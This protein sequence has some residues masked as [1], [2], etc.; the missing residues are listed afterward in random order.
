MNRLEGPKPA[1]RR[2]EP[3]IVLI[4]LGALAAAGV[5]SFAARPEPSPRQV[6]AVALDIS[7][8]NNRDAVCDDLVAIIKSATSVQS[9]HEL[10]ILASGGRDTANEPVKVASFALEP[11]RRLVE[12][13]QAA[14]ARRNQISVEAKQA[15]DRLPIRQESPIFQMVDTAT[16]YFANRRCGTDGLTCLILVRTDGIDETDAIMARRFRD[17]KFKAPPR[18]YNLHI[19]V[20]FCGLSARRTT[21]K[22]RLP[23]LSDVERAFREEFTEPDL[24]SFSPDCS[25]QESLRGGSAR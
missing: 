17:S 20:H 23:S 16:K 8:T 11:S 1:A 7:A 25:S 10:T 15:C 21:G 2:L 24:V 12:G 4:V 6:S 9:T 22:H 3:F 14:H 19:S 13:K 18:I 5:V